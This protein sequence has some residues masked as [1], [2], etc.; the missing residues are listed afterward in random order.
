MA[1]P[2]SMAFLPE[3]Q[4]IKAPLGVILFLIRKHNLDIY[5][6]PIASITKE[7]LQYL[8][9]M[10]RMNIELAGEFFVMAATL[11]RIKAQMLLRKDDE[12]DPRE[13]LVRN[14]VEYQRIV[15]A[16]K[17]LRILEEERMRVF[18]RAVPP[19]EKER[20]AEV[21]IELNL[22]EL[23]KAFREIMANFGEPGVAEIE[24]EPITIEEKIAEIMDLLGRRTQVSFA[25]LFVESG[26]R[27]ELIVTFIALLELMKQAKVRTHQESSFGPIWLYPSPTGEQQ[28]PAAYGGIPPVFG[29]EER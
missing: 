14:I 16:A 18:K 12:D 11:M 20:K 25:E 8:D 19:E 6:I 10:Q 15:E 23:M 9:L 1:E 26:S 7:Y 4:G 5:D 2:L 13:E 28:P 17:S 21:E 29:E 22:Y 24:P 27:L 3:L